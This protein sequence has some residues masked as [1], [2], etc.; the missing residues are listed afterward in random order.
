MGAVMYLNYSPEPLDNFSLRPE[1]YSDP[2]GQRT[3]TA[4]TYWEISIGWQHWFSPQIEMRPEIGY[5]HSNG[6]NAFNGGAAN[7]GGNRNWTLL[8]AGD[9]IWHF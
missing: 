7:P 3:G 4:A 8:G 2:Q 1:I 5:Y 9:V 6:A